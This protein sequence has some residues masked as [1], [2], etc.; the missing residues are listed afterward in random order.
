MAEDRISGRGDKK[1]DR[2]P[3]CRLTELRRQSLENGTER[4]RKMEIVAGSLPQLQRLDEL[5]EHAGQLCRRTRGPRQ[6]F[7]LLLTQGG[8]RQD[9]V[10]A[11]D[12]LQRLA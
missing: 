11:G 3:P 5:A 8:L 10:C 2:F 6:F 1:R 7:P 9:I 4:H 12:K